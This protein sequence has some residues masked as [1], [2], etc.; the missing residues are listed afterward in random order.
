MGHPWNTSLW[1]NVG[2]RQSLMYAGGFLT[3]L[4]LQVVPGLNE[5]WVLCV[6]AHL[7]NEGWV[8]LCMWEAS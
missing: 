2:M 8:L 7:S 1:E 6:A 3:I 4:L 5:R